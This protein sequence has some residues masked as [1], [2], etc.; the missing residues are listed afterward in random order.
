MLMGEYE[1][2][3]RKITCIVCPE[4]CSIKVSIRGGRVDAIE[5]AKCKRGVEYASTEV[6]APRRILTTTVRVSGGTLP[7]APV[8]T[9]I[10]IPKEY[11]PLAMREIAKVVLA[12]PLRCGEV[13]IRDLLGTGADVI[14][15]RNLDATNGRISMKVTADPLQGMPHA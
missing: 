10:P 1:T 4:G 8:R 12:A 6:T 9:S 3:E 13:V 14:V 5:G 11:I 15:T 7:V 2:T